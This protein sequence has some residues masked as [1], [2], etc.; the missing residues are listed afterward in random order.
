MNFALPDLLTLRTAWN[1]LL[2]IAVLG[3][4]SSSV[5]LAMV[6]AAAMR[7]R[8]LS[9][10]AKRAAAAVPRTS[11]P[12][13]TILKPV[14]GMEPQLSENLES[15]FLQDYPNFEIIIGARDENNPAL[16]V[17]QQ[18]RKRYRHVNSKVVLSGPPT[19]RRKCMRRRHRTIL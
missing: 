10:V 3:T 19:W 12:P 4:V 18:L 9:R 6:I 2:A 7:Y 5:F 14:H 13:V 11:L 17:A 15:F 16:Q 8:R 1:L